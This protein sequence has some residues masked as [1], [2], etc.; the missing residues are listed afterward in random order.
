MEQRIRDRFTDAILGE[1]ASRYGVTSDSLVSLGGFESF[2]YRYDQ[3]SSGVILRLAHSLRRT[4]DLIQGEVNFIRYLADN[5]VAVAD[6]IPSIPG[7]LI[8]EIP[9][10]EGG[11]FLVTAFREIKGKTPWDFGWT[12]EL[13]EQY[14]STMGKMHRLAVGY[15]PEKRLRPAWNSHELGGDLTEMIPASQSAVADRI[16]ELE[17]QALALPVEKNSYG[18]VHYDVHEGNM[19]IDRNGRI[20][21]FDF[22][23][24][25]MNWFAFDIAVALF[26]MVTNAEEPEKVAMEFLKPYFQGYSREYS[27]SRKWLEHIPLFLRIREVDMYAVIHR[28][29]DLSSLDVW[30]GKFM[31]GRR[32]RIENGTPY[33]DLDFARFGEHFR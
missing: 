14:G 18:L 28:S 30:C 15:S 16:R 22:D 6:A 26:Y 5:G 24:C 3:G 11:S 10:C 25:S 31:D 4:H 2:I 19:L 8:E 7:N 27:L 9:D 32:E 17:A 23:D 20:N 12:P 13:F 33:L 29:M 1:A 21:L